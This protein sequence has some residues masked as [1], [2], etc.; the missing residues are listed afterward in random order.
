L[1]GPFL[2]DNASCSLGLSLPPS[3][4][5]LWYLQL[6][7]LCW[8]YKQ[9][10]NM[11]P[12]LIKKWKICP[13]SVLPSLPPGSRRSDSSGNVNKAGAFCDQKTSKSFVSQGKNPS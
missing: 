3:P 1:R 5:C 9:C 12:F 4:F 10:L 7:P 13:G 6:F 2:T 8:A 11:L